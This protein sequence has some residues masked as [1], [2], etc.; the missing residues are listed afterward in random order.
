MYDFLIIKLNMNFLAVYMIKI[1]I[2]IT[3]MDALSS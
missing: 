1:T 3:I 2:M